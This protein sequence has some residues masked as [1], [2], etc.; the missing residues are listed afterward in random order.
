MP[1]RTRR[2]RRLGSRK[3]LLAFIVALLTPI[4][5]FVAFLAV[6]GYLAFL[7]KESLKRDEAMAD[8]HLQQGIEHFDEQH[9]DEAI[10]EFNEAIELYNRLAKAHWDRA[11]KEMEKPFSGHLRLFSEDQLSE[12]T[13]E[14][15]RLWSKIREVS[16][17]R[18]I[19]QDL[20]DR[21][22]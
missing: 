11:L 17:K 15:I 9:Y 14:G 8:S 13:E 4:F 18:G 19:A 16:K 22:K 2:V 21:P 5:L 3:I 20:R 1:P 6:T 10:G 7:H 12:S